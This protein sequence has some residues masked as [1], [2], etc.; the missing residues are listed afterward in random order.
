MADAFTHNMV[1]F[2]RLLR[3]QGL[4]GT[5]ETT[6]ALIEAAEAVGLADRDDAYHAFRA[7]VIGRPNEVPVFDQAFELFFGSG[8]RWEPMEPLELK[9]HPH[10]RMHIIAP[11]SV[12]AGAGGE[13]GEEVE[14]DEQLGASA[15]TRLSLRDFTDLST[16]E[17]A[18]VQRLIAR[19]VWQPADT[20]SRRW[21]PSR[22]GSRPDLR[23]T[24]RQMTGPAGE[25]MPLAMSAPKPRRRP[26]LVLADVSGSMERYTEMLLY[27]IHAARGR[28][29]K[30][31]AFVFS[32]HL[33]RITRE[34][35]H[36]DPK[37]AL[38]RVGDAVHDWSSGT[39]IGE[40][41]GDFNRNWSRRVV[42]GG[43]V[44][45]V[46]S[47]GWDRGDPD[48]LRVEMAA[49]ARTVHR[50]V[51][52]NPLAGRAGFAPETRGMRAAMP[53]VDDFLPVGTLSDLAAVVRLL[54]TVPRKRSPRPRPEPATPEPA[55]SP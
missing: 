23:R 37:V 24:L 49:F 43:P 14:L 4:R 13:E 54:E 27:F 55:D 5:P 44:A 10:Q 32:T 17:Y 25:M 45:L 22:S 18:Q 9:V 16:E 52:L 8:R 19:M 42:R 41:L 30:V 7:V 20:R 26:L 39:L 34:L 12:A 35:A 38:S 36:R 40:A 1:H 11:T 2:T 51:W 3:A 15:S 53:Y 50:V 21:R 33:H 31:E 6:V 46:I 28:L 29:G 48:V 47:D